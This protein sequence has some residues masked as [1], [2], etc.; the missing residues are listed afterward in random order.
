M[1]PQRMRGTGGDHAR[2]GVSMKACDKTLATMVLLRDNAIA[3]TP[4]IAADRWQAPTE[5]RDRR[6]ILA[7]WNRGYLIS[8]AWVMKSRQRGETV[9]PRIHV[10]LPPALVGAVT[11]ETRERTTREEGARHADRRLASA[12]LDKRHAH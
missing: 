5:G 4:D 3:G 10:R 12:Y 2:N 11:H 8:L 6:E 1:S 9:R 7:E